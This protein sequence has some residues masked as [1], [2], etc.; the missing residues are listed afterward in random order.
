MQVFKPYKRF[1][2]LFFLICFLSDWAT[3]QSI[4]GLRVVV[5]TDALTVLKFNT[6][7]QRIEIGN[8][9]DYTCKVRDDDNS[10]V[11]RT[12][13]KRPDSTNL[14]VTEG[15]RTHYFF[16]TFKEK[17]DI[18]KDK[19]YYDL[20][21]LKT[22]KR[23]SEEM[24]NQ[25]T[26]MAT[27]TGST[28]T[29]DKKTDD[30]KTEEKKDEEPPKLSKKEKKKLEQEQKAKEEE[31]KKQ[32]WAAENA[33]KEAE[34]KLAAD[35]AEKQKALTLA[36]AKA[37]EE[38]KRIADENERQRLA[39]ENEAKEALK[40]KEEQARLK[41][42]QAKETAKQKEIALAKEK[43]IKR[44]EQE[45]K[46]RKAAKDKEIAA[47]A[48]KEKQRLLDEEKAKRAAEAKAIADAK[49][50][51]T[52]RLADEKKA[53]AQALAEAKE[54]ERLHLQEIADKKKAAQE[55]ALAEA[56]EKE[57]V[58]LQEIA[59]RKKAQQ[60]SLMA[61]AKEKER[62]RQEALEQERLAALDPHQKT[63]QPYTQAQF[64]KKY[65][66]IVYNSM[67][68]GQMLTP[69]FITDSIIYKKEAEK[70]VA[71]EPKHLLVD[72]DELVAVTLENISFDGANTYLKIHVKNKGKADLLTGPMLVY[73]QKA[74]T[75]VKKLWASYI[76]SFPVILPG[77]EL[78]II[79]AFHS[80][81]ATNEDL[82]V[83]EYKDRIKKTSYSIHIPGK[84][85]N[86]ELDHLE[87]DRAV[88][89]KKK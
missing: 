31:E 68:L 43:E 76:S 37:E 39:K 38:K 79:Y 12:Q 78:D 89:T 27:S 2:F 72:E 24:N 32:L 58:R 17:I 29:D 63:P 30:K 56:K 77:K 42:E 15:K 40:E 22:V 23:I 85:Y 9:D 6:H 66:T 14:I 34:A 75:T 3:A 11:I 83:F 4:N 55:K 8:V 49:E 53:K 86:Q 50:K 52:Q 28:K 13:S 71:Q 67:G 70:I 65:P 80:V 33:K 45:E 5:S 20:S 51:E 61:I 87:S 7:I 62:V 84:L 18:N 35:A 57:R 26:S 44:M 41:D 48:V 69:D 19:L 82:L 21:D 60:D 47:A 1:V 81:N 46:D 88:K 16:I 74:D 59:D 36:K 54:K 25:T 64:F 73:W 10:I